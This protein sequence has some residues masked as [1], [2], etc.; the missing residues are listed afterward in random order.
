MRGKKGKD[1]PMLVENK[2]WNGIEQHGLL[3]SGIDTST[4]LIDKVVR[5][6]S[7]D[8]SEFLVVRTKATLLHLM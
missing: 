4:S 1:C 7:K 2:L 3:L 6:K 5:L 8:Q